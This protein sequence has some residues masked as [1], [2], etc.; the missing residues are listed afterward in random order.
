MSRGFTSV[1]RRSKTLINTEN[2]VCSPHAHQAATIMLSVSF[3]ANSAQTKPEQTNNCLAL[4]KRNEQSLLIQT[5][6]PFGPRLPPS[7]LTLLITIPLTR[8]LS[9]YV[10]CVACRGAI[11]SLSARC[12]AYRCI[13]A[14]SAV[15]SKYNVRPR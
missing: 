7:M 8:P 12:P 4:G 13:K 9:L 11:D 1:L 5:L 10:R 3:P 14:L 2:L 6:P 15:S